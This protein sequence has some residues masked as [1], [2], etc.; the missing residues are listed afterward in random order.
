MS[1]PS[2]GWP[3]KRSLFVRSLQVSALSLQAHVICRVVAGQC[4]A[5]AG[6]RKISTIV[7]PWRSP[8]NSC[9]TAVLII[10]KYHPNNQQHKGPCSQPRQSFAAQKFPVEKL[11][12]VHDRSAISDHHELKGQLHPTLAARRVSLT[13]TSWVSLSSCTK[14]HQISSN[15]CIKETQS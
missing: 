9:Q 3:M 8:A 5:L 15:D 10:Q 14:F 13:K 2:L 1:I 7:G 11:R 12:K 6:P 4:A